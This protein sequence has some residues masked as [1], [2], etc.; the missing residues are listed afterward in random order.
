LAYRPEISPYPVITNGDMSLTSI[1][2]KVTIVQKISMFSYSYSWVG[3]SPVGT[4]SVQVSDDYE[5]SANGLTTINTGTWNTLTL[6]VGGTPSTTIAVSGN[7]GNGFV[8]IFQTGAY[9]V[10]TVYT[11]GSGT[12]TLQAIISGKVA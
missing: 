4:L 5:L 12:G 6:N 7:T 9:A 8:D 2:S 1:T 10:R 11:K 3:S